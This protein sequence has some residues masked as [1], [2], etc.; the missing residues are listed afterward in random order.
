M[1]ME[2]SRYDLIAGWGALLSQ[3]AVAGAMRELFRSRWLVIA[4]CIHGIVTDGQTAPEISLPARTADALPGSGVAARLRELTLDAREREMQNEALRGNVPTFWR[5]F[6]SVDM[7][8]VV[9]GRRHHVVVYVAPDYFALGTDADYFLAPLSPL[10]AQKLADA[11]GCILPT[12]KMVDA[13]YHAAGVKLE[14]VRIAP[15]REMISVPVFEQHNRSIWEQREARLAAYPLGVLVAGHKKDVVL[16]PQLA[17]A[18][19]KVAIYGWHDRAGRAI[20]PLYLGH[21]GTWVDYSHGIRFIHRTALL[22]GAEISLTEMLG[23]PSLASLLSEEGVIAEPRYLAVERDTNVEIQFEPDVRASI[24]LPHGTARGSQ[25][26]A[27]RLVI[28]AL[29][30]GNTIEET[31]GRRADGG[32]DWRFDI[33]H[34]AAQTR[35]LRAHS[36][37]EQTVVACVACAEHS[38]PAWRK[39]HGDARIRE[40]VEQLQARFSQGSSPVKV[41]L[42]GHSGGGSFIFGFI[43]ACETLPNDVERIAF[44]DANYAYDPELGHGE[45]LARWLAAPEPHRLAVFAYRD[46]LATLN[47]KPIVSRE[48]GTWARSQWMLCELSARF[49]FISKHDRDLH[50]HTALD[51]RITILLHENPRRE[52]LHTRLVDRNGFIHAL[53]TG[54]RFEEKDYRFFGE[55]VYGDSIASE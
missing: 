50:R 4:I 29:P 41:V 25:G 38:W 9:D 20:Q 5:K 32:D 33:Q 15:S 35:W 27:T 7:T 51:G 8:G 34:I 52:I 12:P 3:C 54:T 47:G 39:K 42:A 17:G 46:D 49:P 30:N 19:G 13:I 31:W 48:G 24:N 55:R 43:N 26:K 10:S 45:K 6:V 14:P 40:I 53:L 22:D 36:D 16:T 37:N 28:Y 11:M 2:S 1:F 23:D 18:P 44:L 21:T